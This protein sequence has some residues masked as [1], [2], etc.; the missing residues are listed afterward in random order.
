MKIISMTFGDLCRSSGGSY[1]FEPIEIFDQH[2]KIYQYADF[3]KNRTW[4]SPL[5]IEIFRPQNAIQKETTIHGREREN[6][7]FHSRSAGKISFSRS[8]F[9]QFC[10]RF[11][12]QKP[13]VLLLLKS[14]RNC[15]ILP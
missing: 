10:S 9:F 8:R 3:H 4:G 7:L 6:G 1:D 5:N 13:I 14:Y 2:V 12:D 15:Q 11:P